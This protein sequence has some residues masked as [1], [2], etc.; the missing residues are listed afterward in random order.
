[1]P[2]KENPLLDQCRLRLSAFMCLSDLF[3]I[4]DLLLS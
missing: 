3:F 1:M 2:N 4:A